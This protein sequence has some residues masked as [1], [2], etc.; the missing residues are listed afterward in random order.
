MRYGVVRLIR[1]GDAQI[2]EAIADG[3]MVSAAQMDMIRKRA[4]RALMRVDLGRGG[5]TSADYQAR[6]LDAR[7]RYSTNAKA[8]NAVQRLGRMILGVYALILLYF[9]FDNAR[10]KG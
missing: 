9:N 7:M 6:I 10:W 4:Q 8:P 5:R 3:M 1:N 2:S